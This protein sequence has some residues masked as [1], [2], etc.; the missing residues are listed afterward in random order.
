MMPMFHIGGL[1]MMLSSLLAGASVVCPPGF[2]APRFF[3]WLQDFHPTWY[4]AT[5][6]MHQ[7]VLARAAS[8]RD[9]I[10]RYPLRFIRSGSAPLPLQVLAELERVFNVPVIDSYGLTET[11][12]LITSNPLPPRARKIGSV[13]VAVGPEVAIMDE[14]GNLL[15]P[16][17]MGEIVVRGATVMQGYEN[18]P[19]ANAAAFMHGWFRTGDQG[20]VDSN[21]Y[22]FLTGRLKELINH[23]GEKITPREIEE[24]LIEHPAVAHVAA[25]AMPHAQLGEEVAVAI[26]L[27]EHA[28][29]TNREI[30]E[31]AAARLADFK[32]PRQV[33]FV[34][35]ILKDATGKVSR[36]GLAQ[37]LGLLNPGQGRPKVKA[38][39]IAPRTSV[40]AI[41]AGIWAEV[42]GIDRVGVYD[43]FF[44][45]GGHSLLAT[46]LISRLHEA[47]GV[48]LPLRSMLETPTV[49]ALAEHTETLR[50]A[51]DLQAPCGDTADGRE[52]GEL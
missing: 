26:M 2:Y 48:E 44:A 22:L 23:G 41:L 29:V 19:A 38:A 5:P 12:A 42:L 16:G 24:V 31:F 35:E 49:A 1:M 17:E 11:T 47:F 20:Y 36:V 13:G 4:M 45:L 10:E 15:S 7:A 9:I 46:Q 25:F 40:E 8:H 18:N 39:F 6:P 43:N 30:R 28:V 33:I 51:Q 52:E 27:H 21:G 37:Q 50:W 3:A 34:D 14:A 32:V